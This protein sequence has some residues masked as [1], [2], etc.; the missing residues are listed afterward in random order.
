VFTGI[1]EEV[2]AV[3]AADGRG[4]TIG[5]RLVLEGLRLGDSIAVD[6]ACL[7]V[8][9]LAGASFTVGTQPETIRRTTLGSARPGRRVNLERALLADGR[10]GGHFVQGHVDGTARL[11]ETFRDGEAIGLRFTAEDGITRYIVEKGFVAID[12]V[13]LTVVEVTTS[14]FAITLIP[15]TQLHVALLDKRPGDLVNVE[16][17]IVAKY[18]ERFVVGGG[19]SEGR[20]TEEFLARHGFA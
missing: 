18:V 5:A 14:G 13:S 12:G 1:V 10:L 6:G 9:A 16:V 17:D 15:Y 4:L 3:H 11:V 20:V 8:T 2:G 7:T 19:P